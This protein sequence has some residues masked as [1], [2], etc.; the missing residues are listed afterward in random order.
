MYIEDIDGVTGRIK[1]HIHHQELPEGNYTLDI[2]E[3][4]LC[5]YYDGSANKYTFIC[6]GHVPDYGGNDR[7]GADEGK[8]KV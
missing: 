5:R 2:S 6:A 1:V 7:R 3:R 8:D 4:G